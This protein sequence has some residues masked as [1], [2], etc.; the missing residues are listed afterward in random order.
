MIRKMP[1]EWNGFDKP[2]I[3]LL[4]LLIFIAIGRYNSVNMGANEYKYYFSFVSLTIS[5]SL[6]VIIRSACDAIISS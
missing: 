4:S 3:A 2:L 6:I 1:E 5:P